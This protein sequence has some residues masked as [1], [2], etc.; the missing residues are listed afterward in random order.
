MENQ[1]IIYSGVCNIILTLYLYEISRRNIVKAYKDKKI[2]KG[3]AKLYQGKAPEYL[4][5]SRQT[6]K[7][8]FEIPIIFYFWISLVV[9]TGNVS[10]LD[11]IF[12]WLFVISRYIHCYLRL[13]SNYIPYRAKVFTL[14]IL[15]L[16]GG[17][18]NFLL[19]I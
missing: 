11:I 19:N 18:I 1:L 9:S 15:F 5:L 2:D 16:I 4:E 6:L 7:N 12:S 13:T 10:L 17:W 8:Q 14:G 3:Y